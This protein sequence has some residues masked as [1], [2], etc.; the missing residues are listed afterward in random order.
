MPGRQPTDSPSLPEGDELA[1]WSQR[2]DGG[3]EISH[4]VPV[5]QV[6]WH[7]RGDYLSTVSPSGNAQV[8]S[9]GEVGGECGILG[10]VWYA[11]RACRPMGFSHGRL[12]MQNRY[13]SSFSGAVM[14]T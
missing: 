12:V 7:S 3:L 5:R 9:V 10:F 4:R 14:F 11:Q 2:T 6:A 8:G 1:S 13:T